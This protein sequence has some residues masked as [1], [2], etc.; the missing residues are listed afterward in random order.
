[1]YLSS[2]VFLPSCLGPKF[3]AG[4][5]ILYDSGVVEILDQDLGRYKAS[6]H[7]MV[8]IKSP[9]VGSLSPTSYFTSIEFHWVVCVLFHYISH[10]GLQFFKWK[11]VKISSSSSLEDLHSC[12]SIIGKSQKWYRKAV[13]WACCNDMSRCYCRSS[14]TCT[15]TV[16]HEVMSSTG[17]RSSKFINNNVGMQLIK[18]IRY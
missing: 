7:I 4:C 11:V 16:N 15:G 8:P 12:C 2:V 9:H 18:P 3:Q 6:D 5:I 14:R 17:A 1:M 10:Q 13:L